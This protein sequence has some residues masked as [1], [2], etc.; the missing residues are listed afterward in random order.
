MHTA[1]SLIAVVLLLVFIESKADFHNLGRDFYGPYDYTNPEHFRDKLPIVEVN[2][3]TPAIETLRDPETAGAHLWYTINH[4]PNHH[5]A[6]NSMAK[7]WRQYLAK[8]EIPPRVPR[9]KPPEYLFERAIKFAPHDATVRLLYG[10]HLQKMGL[11]ERAITLYKQAEE[12]QPSSAEIHYI[13]GLVYAEQKDY[14]LAVLHAKKAY[15]LGFPLPGLRNKL[16]RAG[17]WKP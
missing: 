13:L 1:I 5:G 10:I 8:G 14:Q 12:L 11:P 15:K 6:L 17:V 3:F 9:G 4:F 2:H 7:L 16:I